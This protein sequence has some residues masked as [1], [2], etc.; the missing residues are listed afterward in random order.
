MADR[1]KPTADQKAEQKVKYYKALEDKY[2]KRYA[3]AQGKAIR[4]GQT[5]QSTKDPKKKAKLKAELT[6]LNKLADARYKPY[7]RYKKLRKNAEK[8]QKALH[9]QKGDLDAIAE[10]IKQH[11][12]QLSI[13]PSSQFNEGHAAI[14]P[15]DGS[16]NPVFISPSDNESEDTTSNVTSWAVDDGAPRADYIR[17]ASKTVS[18]GGIIAGRNRT[19]ANEKY[20][21]L[22]S[23]H[24]HHKQLT[25]R[26]D[27]NYKHLMINDL[28]QSFSDLRD[29]LKV[30][31]SFTFVYWAKV[32]TS[33]GKNSK[34]KTSK[35]S[36]RVAGN[37]NK[38]YT[39]ITVKRGQTLWGLAKRYNTTVK[40]LQTVNHIKNPNVIDTGQHL[41]VGT[42]TN[43][44][45]RGKIRVK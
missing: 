15:S 22:D 23:W 6:K 35:S 32:T 17:V 27:I 37:R 38:K 39:A 40:W 24:N 11:N 41:F 19:E 18:V 20:A 42:K 9:K 28:Q 8:E 43:K 5:M 36:K 4:T 2:Q 21:K 12:S 26:G 13:D 1:K 33:T 7:N 29:N 44:K 31:I 10:K 16:Q 30:S 14:Y 45:A 34:K 3:Q 25:Y